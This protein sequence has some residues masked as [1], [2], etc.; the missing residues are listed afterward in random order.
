MAIHENNNNTKKM[1]KALAG[2]DNIIC[3]GGS[4]LKRLIDL[5]QTS[6]LLEN[7]ATKLTSLAVG[8]ATTKPTDS[9]SSIIHQLKNVKINPCD[10]IVLWPAANYFN[11]SNYKG[12]LQSYYDR[13]VEIEYWKEE[14]HKSQFLVILPLLRGSDPYYFSEQVKEMNRFKSR[15]SKND[16]YFID[17]LQ[18][19]MTS[20][21]TTTPHQ[22][23]Y[24]FRNPQI[25]FDK[26]ARGIDTIHYNKRTLQDVQRELVIK[27]IQIEKNNNNILDI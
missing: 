5:Q 3:I 12:F 27:L 16:Y 13:L 26:T 6:P 15:L 7:A 14:V 20:Y 9:P 2:Y 4:N 17:P 18:T 21:G 1:E 23:H 22:Y 11:Y 8:G 19:I 25:I 10:Q 24:L